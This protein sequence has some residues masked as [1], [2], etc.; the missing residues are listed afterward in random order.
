MANEKNLMPPAKKGE[1]RNPNGR[2][3]GTKNRTTIVRQIMEMTGV[4]PDTILANL[5]ARYPAMKGKLS[6]EEII[7]IQQIDKAIMQQDTAAYKAVMDSAYGTPKN[8]LTGPDD[9]PLQTETVVRHEVT[10]EGLTAFDEFF[11]KRY[12]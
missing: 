6:I 2:K 4:L 11:R 1:V 9:G 5:T 8:T 10:P 7:T 3:P 12:Q